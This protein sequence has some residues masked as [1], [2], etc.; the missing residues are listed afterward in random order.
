MPLCVV[1]ESSRNSGVAAPK[2]HAG[3]IYINH[4]VLLLLL[5]I[6]KF[7]HVS[8]CCEVLFLFQVTSRDLMSIDR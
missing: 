3:D 1:F 5:I 7:K 4:G 6:E 8:S 2:M